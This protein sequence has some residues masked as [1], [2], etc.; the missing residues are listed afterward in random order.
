MILLPKTE[1][2]LSLK[3]GFPGAFRLGKKDLYW[4]TVIPGEEN[5]V[6]QTVATREVVCFVSCHI[7]L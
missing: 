7:L 1:G 6:D 4:N 3:Q 5:L 2:H